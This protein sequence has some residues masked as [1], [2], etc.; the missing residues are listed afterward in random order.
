MSPVI[1]KYQDELIEFIAKKKAKP[2]IKSEAD[3]RKSLNI[4]F[5]NEESKKQEPQ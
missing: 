5:N 4:K 1:F 3:P 2:S